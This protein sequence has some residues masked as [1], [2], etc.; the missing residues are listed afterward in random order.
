MEALIEEN[1]IKH[2][3]MKLCITLQNVASTAD[4]LRRTVIPQTIPEWIK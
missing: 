1:P 3:A 4:M 2:D